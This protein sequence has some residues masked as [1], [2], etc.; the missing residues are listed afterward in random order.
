M[1]QVRL[2]VSQ[3]NMCNEN[4]S[5]VKMTGKITNPSPLLG[6]ACWPRATGCILS[7]PGP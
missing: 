6:V 2:K 7:P 1:I 4:N 3:S 5:Q